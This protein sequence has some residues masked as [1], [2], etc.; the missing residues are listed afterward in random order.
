M[1]K[2]KITKSDNDILYKITI[3]DQVINIIPIHLP[4]I[5]FTFY[6]LRNISPYQNNNLKTNDD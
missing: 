2:Y 4:D 5:L 6:T 1:S 3:D